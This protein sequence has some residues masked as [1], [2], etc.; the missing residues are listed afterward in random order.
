MYIK[1]CIMHAH[2]TSAYTYICMLDSIF[3]LT[4]F[5]ASLLGD[6]KYHSHKRQIAK[7]YTLKLFLPRMKR[8]RPEEQHNNENMRYACIYV[9]YR[10]S[11]F[12]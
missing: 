2:I 12:E 5:N 4:F 3:W 10:V 11:H 8:I 9:Y 7:L 6:L 1:I